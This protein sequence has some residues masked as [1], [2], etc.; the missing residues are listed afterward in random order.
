MTALTRSSRIV[1][2]DN[3]KVQWQQKVKNIGIFPLRY[4]DKFP[5]KD[6]IWLALT[7]NWISEEVTI[8][9][10]NLIEMILKQLWNLWNSQKYILIHFYSSSVH[11]L[12][13]VLTG[14]VNNLL[15]SE[16]AEQEK[17][18]CATYIIFFFFTSGSF[19]GAV[20]ETR[21]SHAGYVSAAQWN[22][23]DQKRRGD[24]TRALRTSV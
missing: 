15:I 6:S 11:S 4:V 2:T 9:T 1:Y 18:K 20:T 10:W 3:V 7:A 22:P 17:H 8:K 24:A 13:T 21:F 14:I 12:S 19:A 23:G 5:I 16:L